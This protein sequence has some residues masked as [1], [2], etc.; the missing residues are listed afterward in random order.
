MRQLL[1]LTLFALPALAQDPIFLDQGWNAD[2][3]DEFYFTPQGS[4]LIPYKWFLHLEQQN[5]QSLFRDNA[6]M[7][8]LG[9]LPAKP[10]KRNPDGLPV[11]FVRGGVDPTRS[12]NRTVAKN[13][14]IARQAMADIKERYIGRNFDEKLYPKEADSWFGLTCAACHTHEIDYRGKTIRI[15]GGSTQADFESF[16]KELGL[17]LN[18]THSNPD[19]LERFR[20]AVGRGSLASSFRSEVEQISDAVN[21]LVDRNKAPHPYGYARLD[22][23][24]AIFNAVCET[25]L[26]LPDNRR[27]SD[28]PVSYP[29]IWNAA[30]QTWVQW[31]ASASFPEA[32]NVGEVLGVFG[33]Y[34]VK[35][36]STQFDSTVRLENLVR[37]EHGLIKKLRSPD[38]P[39]EVL[40][41]LDQKKIRLGRTLFK[42]NCQACHPVRNANG[43]F[44]L[45]ATG[46][47]PVFRADVGTDLKYLTNLSPENPKNTV[48][49][50][51]LAGL[52][53][54]VEEVRGELVSAVVRGVMV[55]RA[56]IESV[57]LAKLNPGPQPQPGPA[58]GYISEPLEGIWATAPYFHNGS[59][60]NLYETLLPSK[61]SPDYDGPIRS[62]TF[63]VGNREF[64]PVN[65]GFVTTK[66]PIGSEF[67]TSLPA[68]GNAG[69]EGHRKTETLEDGK[70]R[71]FTH[72]ERMALVEYMKS[73][74]ARP[75]AKSA[76]AQLEEVPEGE[77]KQIQNI[78]RLT[79]KRMRKQYASSRMLRGVHPKDHGCV[80][81]KFK[82]N[83]DLPKRMRVGVFKP[84]AEYDAFIR[85]SN[86]AVV[87]GADST[88]TE[89]GAVHGS[90]GMA[91]KLL[92][93]KGKSLLPLHG[94]LTQDFLL[95]N[96]PSFAFAN[97]ADYEVLTQ[98]LD[99]GKSAT[100]FLKRQLTSGDD[101][102]KQRA[103]A[104]GLIAKRIAADKVDGDTGAFEPPP[105]SPADATYF[106]AAPFLF[107][108]GRVMKYRAKPIARTMDK[109][110]VSDPDYLRT[111]LIR[112]L[113][114]EDIEFEFALQV[115]KRD[116][117]D[118]GK[119]IENASTVWDDK[120]IPVA[121]IT[122]PKQNFDSPEQRERCERLF[123]TPWHGVTS[124]VPLG[125]INR[126]RK[127]VYLVSGKFRSLPHEPASMD[128][129]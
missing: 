49:T 120:F 42:K 53:G 10:S 96:Q 124:H 52:L 16:L 68:N 55:K 43:Q 28:A 9:I 5:N 71:P 102:A 1:L 107:G 27:L 94:A 112:R 61:K 60:P 33:A 125:G 32:R 35:P 4:H 128:D 86:A 51:E 118:I 89:S 126:L 46:K 6:N 98:V 76:T 101:A 109:P 113:G 92:G 66:G 123:F 26:D 12:P 115:R 15:E 87:V 72:D 74:S 23:F 78:V 20:K 106:G 31:G 36:G 54:K 21:A 88:K 13:A 79:A 119:D 39:E 100:E 47:I 58:G 8:R 81:A 50:G 95:V 40:G 67:D 48:K 103:Q 14:S 117:L 70:W 93:V 110:D 90:R 64:D 111:A 45:T 57:D 122:I 105:A 25:A 7:Q 80:T 44:K 29:S 38:W 62:K 73:L 24:G 104:T 34:T 63:Y 19:K 114:K 11:G 3:I 83:P 18:A 2:E 99:E 129:K 37:L 108:R 127:A 116:Q 59:V 84:G 75:Q 65:V 77:Q 82:V 41:P 85:F 17:A 22:A 97:V 121:T 91:I 30:D 56:Q 69:H